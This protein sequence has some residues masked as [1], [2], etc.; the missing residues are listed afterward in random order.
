MMVFVLKTMC[1]IESLLYQI[2][3]L[4]SCICYSFH[5]NKREASLSVQPT[6]MYIYNL[7]I[8]TCKK[9]WGFINNI[10]HKNVLAIH[11]IV[12]FHSLKIS[13]NESFPFFQSDAGLKTFAFISIILFFTYWQKICH[14]LN[15]HIICFLTLI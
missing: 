12:Y 1:Q 15:V 6:Y 10:E 13:M 14:L 8:Q 4:F 5:G 2:M 3:L 7:I 11:I 9:Y